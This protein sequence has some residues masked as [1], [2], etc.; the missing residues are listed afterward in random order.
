MNHMHL[1]V[2]N[3]HRVLYDYMYVGIYP[4]NSEHHGSLLL[5]E[6]FPIVCRQGT[7]PSD[8]VNNK[9]RTNTQRSPSPDRSGDLSDDSTTPDDNWSGSHP[10]DVGRVDDRTIRQ[11]RDMIEGRTMSVRTGFTDPFTHPSQPWVL[12]SNSSPLRATPRTDSRVRSRTDHATPD[13]PRTRDHPHRPE[14]S[15]SRSSTSTS[16]PA[17][18]GAPTDLS[19]RDMPELM[20][21]E[22]DGD[23]AVRLQAYFDYEERRMRWLQT[24]VQSETSP[25]AQSQR[26]IPVPIE[27]QPISPTTELVDG[28]VN[29]ANNTHDA[30]SDARLAATMQASFANEYLPD[31][32]NAS[33]WTDP[34]PNTTYCDMSELPVQELLV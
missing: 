11:I 6:R 22:S 19:A 8:T 26:N 20:A 5:T 29:D 18:N 2:H 15:G 7:D 14:N 33:M 27:V 3:L 30:A 4:F 31:D 23:Y 25:R 24:R 13:R 10:N 9:T 12:L 32:Q 16:S 21:D 28:S 17:L 1:L 34:Y